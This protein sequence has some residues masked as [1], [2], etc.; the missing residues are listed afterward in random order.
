[1]VLGR[2]GLPLL[3]GNPP[4]VQSLAGQKNH[5]NV[6]NDSGRG[7]CKDSECHPE[8]RCDNPKNETSFVLSA[9][10]VD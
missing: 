5:R 4:L 6:G 9:Q 10:I 2:T 8:Y 7:F 3:F 1:M